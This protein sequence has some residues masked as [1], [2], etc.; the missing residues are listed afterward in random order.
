MVAAMLTLALLACTPATTVSDSKDPGGGGDTSGGDTA[1]SG[2]AEGEYTGPALVINEA[3]PDIQSDA[4]T[5][6]QGG[7][8]VEIYNPT[9]ADVALDA[10]WL[11]KNSLA[12][13]VAAQFPA[14]TTVKAGG[15]LLVGLDSWEGVADVVLPFKINLDGDNVTLYVM[16][17][18]GT[19]GVAD[20]V[21]WTGVVA[22][23]ESYARVPDG[24][25]WAH[26]QT[27]TPGQANK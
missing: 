16:N 23:P 1:G 3:M 22:L 15:Y 8:W 14:G 5:P 17:A 9:A 2:V 20:R 6:D 27:P 18:D 13:G 11:D 19:A 26:T 25:T 10:Y 21:E 4:T 24:G 7:D 12:A